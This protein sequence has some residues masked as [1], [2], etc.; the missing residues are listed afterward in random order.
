MDGTLVRSDT[1]VELWIRALKKSVWRSLAMLPLMLRSRAQFKAALA[2][3]VDINPRALPYDEDLLDYLRVQ[4]S[5]G[6]KLV[7]ATASNER[8]AAAV[9]T[10]LEVFDDVVA[11]DDH[12]NMKGAAKARALEER[13]GKDF[14]YAGNDRAD[15]KVWDKASAA[16]LVGVSRAVR[17]QVRTPIEAV[18]ARGSRVKALLQAMRPHQWVK[19]VLVFLPVI[20]A[21]AVLD[22][23]SMY[24]AGL[25]F[26]CFSIVASGVY[27]IND[28]LDLEADRAHASKRRRAL[29]DGRAPLAW[30][31]VLGPA[32]VVFGLLAGLFVSATLGAILFLYIILTTAYSVVLKT[33]PLVDVFTLAGLYTARVVAG[34]VVTGHVPS[35]WL[36]SFSGFLFLSL[37]FLKRYVELA[38]LRSMGVSDVMRRGYMAVEDIAMFVLG[39]ASAFSAAI[40]LSLYVELSIGGRSYEHPQLIWGLVPLALF[41]LCRLWLAAFR[42]YML[43]DPIAYAARDWV[44]HLVAAS[45]GVIYILAAYPIV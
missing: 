17:S 22:F 27:L 32:L 1:L 18:F 31:L 33:L 26:A 24:L 37:A 35:I 2:R 30:A 19:N 8:V 13:Y 34:G 25:A 4:R 44:S 38:S 20:T 16:V 23:G 42:G 21:N 3:F 5:A 36:L 28:L 39:I 29:A 7:L 40:V 9:A 10:H 15:L 43:A 6:R 11:S 12:V 41:W 14:S 45:M